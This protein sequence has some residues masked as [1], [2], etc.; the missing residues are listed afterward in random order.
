MRAVGLDVAHLT[1]IQPYRGAAASR[2]LESAHGMALPEPGR[3]TGRKEARAVWFG[4]DC[5]M[6][7]GPAPDEALRAHAAVVDQSDAWIPVA[8]EGPGVRDVLARLTPA[9]LRDGVFRRGH[10]AR[11]ELAHM[12]ASVTRLGRDRYAIMVFRSFA[13]T[14]ADD[15]GEAMRG[16]A[17]RLK[18]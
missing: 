17:G 1:A 5:V 13:R 10:T 8:L 11:T 6:L 3:T 15:L 18:A 9:D 14:L 7:L 2:A 12:A 4:R 16:V